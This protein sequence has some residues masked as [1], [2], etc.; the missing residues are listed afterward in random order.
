MYGTWH[1]SLSE[2]EGEIVGRKEKTRRLWFKSIVITLIFAILFFVNIDA[3]EDK[4]VFLRIFKQNVKWIEH[5]VESYSPLFLATIVMTII[6]WSMFKLSISVNK[7]S[8]AGVDISLKDSDKAVKNAVKNYLNTKRSLFFF[9]SEYDNICEVFDS[10]HCIYDFLRAQM[11]EFEGK[12]KIDSIVYLEIQEM[13]R[14]LNKFLTL[15]QSDFRRWFAFYERKNTESFI[16]LGEFQKK[17]PRFDELINDFCDLNKSMRRHSQ[18]FGVTILDW[19]YDKIAN[20][21]QGQ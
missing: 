5:I 1:S 13:L 10:Y 8:F 17:Y 9:K 11:H 3:I 2:K 20:D 12:E 6:F 15:Y 18:F 14:E 16:S 19:E 21:Y 7:I 4:C